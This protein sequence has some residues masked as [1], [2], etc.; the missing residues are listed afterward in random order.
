MKAQ[1]TRRL[2]SSAKPQERPYE[3]RDISS[4]G[5][6]LRVQPSGHKAWIV[7]WTR[8]KRR[9]LGAVD[10]ISL[11]EA[12][13]QAAQAVAEY[14]Q[15]GLPALSKPRV[16]SCTLRTFLAD[17][18]GPWASI[19][20]K[21]GPRYI[22]AMTSAFPGLLDTPIS[23]IEASAIDQWWKAGLT[24]NHPKIGRPVT[25]ATLSRHLSSLRSAFTQAV[26]WKMLNKNPLLGL[27]N[28]LVES[29]KV[30]RFLGADEEARLRGALGSR[31]TAKVNARGTG[32][33]WRSARRR[34]PL[35][36]LPTGGQGDHLTPIVLLAINTGLRRGE[37][38]SLLWKDIS[39]DAKIVTVRAEN[40]KN[41]R[42]RYIPLNNEAIS[43]LNQWRAQTA[44]QGKVFAPNEIKTA[45]VNLLRA[46]KITGFRFHD[47][48]HHFASKLVMKGV[49]LNTVRE[50]LGHSDLKMTLRYAHLAPAHLAAAVSKLDQ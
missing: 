33:S 50:L 24:T 6:I 26:E 28:K 23:E 39:F 9:T 47:L 35:P 27:K 49:D 20:L 45:W 16:V 40:A 7:E 38:L 29:R 44:P 1:I 17:H 30:I 14:V 15:S 2:A 22:Q 11:D 31:D 10:S 19:E 48:R 37:L 4:K 46:A 41:G 8:G 43:V 3:I 25:K 5:L 36:S 32:N 21:R 42:P 18:Y 13:A 12:R 34:E